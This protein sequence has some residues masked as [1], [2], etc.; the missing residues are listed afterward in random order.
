MQHWEA[1]TG[2]VQAAKAVVAAS[3]L[4]ALSDFSVLPETV[5]CM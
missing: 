5:E 4:T 3:Y 1:C 2:S